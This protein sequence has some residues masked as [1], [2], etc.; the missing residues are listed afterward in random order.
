MANAKAVGFTEVEGAV[1]EKPVMS[2]MQSLKFYD[3]DG[4]GKLSDLERVCMK[5]DTNADGTFSMLEVKAIVQDMQTAKK[6]AKNMGRLAAGIAIVSLLICGAL[7]GLMFAANEGSKESH[8]KGSQPALTAKGGSLLVATAEATEDIELYLAPVLPDDVLHR[9]KSMTINVDG[10]TVDDIPIGLPMNDRRRTNDE[11]VEAEN[12]ENENVEVSTEF[13]LRV[14]GYAKVSDTEIIFSTGDGS[15]LRI[16]GGSAYF[17]Y[18]GTSFDQKTYMACGQSAT[19]SSLDINGAI[20]VAEYKAKADA[21][22]A[23]AGYGRRML[24]DVHRKLKGKRVDIL[25]TKLCVQNPDSK[26]RSTRTSE[27]KIMKYFED[28]INKAPNYVR[29]LEGRDLDCYLY[30]NV[31]LVAKSDRLLWEEIRQRCRNN[32]GN[33]RQNMKD[34]AIDKWI[35]MDTACVMES[36]PCTSGEF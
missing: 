26:K 34:G 31:G 32:G 29:N 16:S 5:Y 22:L 3:A 24:G 30:T 15:N 10:V 13:G 12:A 25:C 20:N 4:D 6:Q 7:F 27:S 28:F 23:D 1:S 17:E 14:T 18:K 35:T 19:C 36:D 21:A 9:I 33:C 2:K 11:N 8:V